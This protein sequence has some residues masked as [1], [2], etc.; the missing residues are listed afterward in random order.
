MDNYV[1]S[2]NFKC[3]R[4]D[5][6]GKIKKVV[7]FLTQVPKST[8]FQ[9]GKMSCYNTSIKIDL[10]ASADGL[11]KI[12]L[13]FKKP[14]LSN[15]NELTFKRQNDHEIYYTL[16]KTQ[17]Q[18]LYNY[19]D[20]LLKIDLPFTW[21][22][23]FNTGNNFI[24]EVKGN[25]NNYNP[26][27]YTEI[28]NL[29]DSAK[30]KFQ[31]IQRDVHYWPIREFI[32]EQELSICKNSIHIPEN[33][34]E[35]IYLKKI[36]IILDNNNLKEIENWKLYAYNTVISEFPASLTFKKKV[37]SDGFADSMTFETNM[38]L[39]EIEFEP[40]FSLTNNEFF[41]SFDKKVTIKKMLFEGINIRTN[42]LK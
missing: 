22:A 20:T 9:K 3:F 30:E 33:V 18:M 42:F 25:F 40:F 13:D 27:C 6:T 10:Y 11:S 16:T 19:T 35:L 14:F 38:E 1:S 17:L 28:I 12:I 24:L 26:E 4:N 7:D 31:F 39:H 36:Y 21:F 8:R 34:E 29:C 32:E 15:I 2:M 23:Y 37:Y 5:S 41:L